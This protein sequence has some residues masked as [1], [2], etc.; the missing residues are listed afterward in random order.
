MDVRGRR[1]RPGQKRESKPRWLLVAVIFMV[2]PTTARGQSS[3]KVQATEKQDPAVETTPSGEGGVV[4]PRSSTIP[5]SARPDPESQPATGQQSS[6]YDLLGTLYLDWFR[7]GY[8]DESSSSQLSTRFKF[9]MGQRPGEGWRIRIDL[10]DR[11][12]PEASGGNQLIIYDA[13]LVL[14]DR[15]N[16]WTLTL[17]Q[18]NLY[19]SA[20]VGELLGG[21]FEY[22][23]EDPW[24]VGGYGGLEPQIYEASIDTGYQKAGL[25]ARYDGDRARCAMVS[26]NVLRFAGETERQFLYFSGL[27][28]VERLILYGNMEYELGPHV[29]QPDRLSRVFVN[30]RYDVT[31]TIDVTANY[32]AG[33]G[34]DYH[35]FLLEKSQDPRLNQA[36][37]E[38][39]YYSSQLGV[40]LGVRVHPSGRVFIEQRVSEHKDRGIR[41]NT[42]RLGG[43]AYDVAGSRFS[44]HGSYS[45]N[46][47]DAAESNDFRFSASRDFGLL[48]WTAYYSTS[49]NAIRFDTVSGRPEV[50][51]L[52][53]RKTLSNDLFFAVSDALAL[54]FELELSSLGGASETSVFARAIYRFQE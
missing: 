53:D 25:F 29:V 50:V 6:D 43:S 13:A 20:G 19:D 1:V 34:L 5:S 30:G 33:K 14:D 17:G 42:T 4:P 10:R 47:G 39:F 44:F 12:A 11:W 3:T 48:S 52:A 27:A 9:R 18:M 2:A 31:D 49:F 7:I 32:S 45:I 37:L 38:R 40:R 35:R 22:R 15:R 46:R 41:N 8:S 51:H 54:S 23:G 16:P 24:T 21:L 26:Y 28:P 36:E